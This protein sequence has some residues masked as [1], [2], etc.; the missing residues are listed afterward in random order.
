MKVFL[1]LL[2]SSFLFVNAAP[3]VLQPRTPAR[4][5]AILQPSN[6]YLESKLVVAFFYN[7]CRADRKTQF[8]KNIKSVLN[9]L[10]EAAAGNNLITFLEVNLNNKKTCRLADDFEI[11]NN[12][13]NLLFFKNGDLISTGVTSIGCN[14]NFSAGDLLRTIKDLWCQELG[15]IRQDRIDEL[16]REQELYAESGYYASPWIWGG[17]FYRG[18]VGWTPWYGYSPYNIWPYSGSVIGS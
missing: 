6:D 8:G 15:E 3:R 11:N 9:V 18:Y 2:L 4:F 13:P 12:C 16:H 7:L 1:I 10:K 17:P 14:W 5:Y